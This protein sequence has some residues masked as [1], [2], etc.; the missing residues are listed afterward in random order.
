MIERIDLHEIYALIG[1]E[2]N[3]AKVYD[4][5]NAIYFYLKDAG[6][7]NLQKLHEMS[8]FDSVELNGSRLVISGKG[9]N[10]M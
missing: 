8:D 7:V 3:I 1:G 4:K 9:E 5:E 2:S 10:D 6:I